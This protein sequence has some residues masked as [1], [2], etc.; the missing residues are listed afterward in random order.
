MGIYYKNVEKYLD[1]IDS[2]AWLEIGVDRGEG[3]TA[4]FSNLA[5]NKNV[6][7]YGIDADTNQINRAIAALTIDG[8]LPNHVTLASARGEDWLSVNTDK[9]FSLVYLDNFDWNYWLDIPEEPFVPGQ[10]QH[11]K[12]V[13][14]VEM[15]NINS[16]LVHLAQAIRLMPLMSKNSIIVCDDTWYEPKE[17]IFIGKCSAVIPFLLTQGFKLLDNQGYRNHNGGAGATLGRFST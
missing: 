3:S 11:Y 13:L 4:F 15:L 14:K 6:N 5:A 1:K 8:K 12:D 17:G 2:D 16:Q 7:F 10:R 9:K